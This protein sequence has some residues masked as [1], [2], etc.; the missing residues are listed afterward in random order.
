MKTGTEYD[1]VGKSTATCQISLS[2]SKVMQRARPKNKIFIKD[3]LPTCDKCRKKEYFDWFFFV[4]VFSV[5]FFLSRPQML[6]A[7]LYHSEHKN[8][9]LLGF[10]H[11]EFTAYF[12][13]SYKHRFSL[14]LDNSNELVIEQIL[15]TN[16][17]IEKNPWYT[18]FSSIIILIC[19][20]CFV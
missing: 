7:F 6:V 17:C 14:S 15:K 5:C 8:N 13:R 4:F 19:I 9:N 1:S 18:S 10:F 2:F 12:S 3:K 20:R 16:F 11:I